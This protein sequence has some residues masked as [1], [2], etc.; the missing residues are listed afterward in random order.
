[1]SY[2][3]LD[4]GWG[5]GQFF[6]TDTLDT[7][8][9]LSALKAVNYSNQTSISNAVLYLVTNQNTDGGWGFYAGDDSNVYMTAMV[10]YTL[11]QFARTSSI[12]TVLNNAMNY[13]VAHQN[14]DGGFGSSP[15]TVYE[16]ALSFLSLMGSGQGTA[17]PL[18]NAMNYIT[19]TQ[20]ADGS[21][22]EDAV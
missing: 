6:S 21:W 1:M 14:S 3:N 10:S 4:N 22:N 7:A 2:Q 15:S 16:T 17:L 13:L 18:Q 8:L 12:A 20:S 5:I 11:E 19:A 9:A